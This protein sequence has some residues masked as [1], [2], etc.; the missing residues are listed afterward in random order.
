MIGIV[1]VVKVDHRDCNCDCY[2]DSCYYHYLLLSLLLL[3][4]ILV[5]NV[6]I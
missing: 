2:Y 4:L 5:Q 3:L 1:F 6:M